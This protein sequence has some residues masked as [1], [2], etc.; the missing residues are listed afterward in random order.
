[1]PYH[2]EDLGMVPLAFN[3]QT[4]LHLFKFSGAVKE[5]DQRQYEVALQC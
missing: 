2:C 5:T 1:M 3:K 4:D